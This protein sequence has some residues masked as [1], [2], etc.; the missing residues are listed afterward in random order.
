MKLRGGG[1]CL[2]GRRLLLFPWDVEL[3]PEAGAS[4]STGCLEAR[5]DGRVAHKRYPRWET[6]IVGQVTVPEGEVRL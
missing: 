1:N 3:Q 4:T 5:H 2:E 6:L